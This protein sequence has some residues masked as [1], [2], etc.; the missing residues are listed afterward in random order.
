[1]FL[2]YEV[3]DRTRVENCRE[4]E[5]EGHGIE[6]TNPPEAHQLQKTEFGAITGVAILVNSNTQI[7]IKMNTSFVT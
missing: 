3:Q 6:E 2:Q 4:H 7:N 5:G 1:M